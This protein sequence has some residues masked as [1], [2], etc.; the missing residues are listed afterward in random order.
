MTNLND[1]N[2]SDNEWMICNDDA[3]ISKYF[4]VYYWAGEILRETVVWFDYF[5]CTNII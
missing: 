1:N 3:N 2:D 5:D 4:S